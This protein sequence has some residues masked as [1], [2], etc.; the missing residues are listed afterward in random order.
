M[1]SEP[2]VNYEPPDMQTPSSIT[3]LI[4]LAAEAR[5]REFFDDYDEFSPAMQ[6]QAR[7]L[8]QFSLAGE[9]TDTSLRDLIA[10]TLHFWRECNQ[11]RFHDMHLACIHDRTKFR[12][13]LRSVQI[14]QFVN[15][16][17]HTLSVLPEYAG[18]DQYHV[19]IDGIEP[20]G[21]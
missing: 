4:H 5:A 9:L 20:D 12:N 7:M 16:L 8:M 14:D 15:G 19:G 18:D 17:I 6:A 11:A 2:R 13:L 1:P 3:E 10:V 21:S